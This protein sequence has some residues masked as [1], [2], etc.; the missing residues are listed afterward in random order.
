MPTRPLEDAWP[1]IVNSTGV[2]GTGT[3]ITKEKLDE[4]REAIDG[5]IY[6]PNLSEDPPA[7]A[8]EVTTARGGYVSVDAR[9]DA[10]EIAAAG[11]AASASSG[12]AQL[13]LCPNDP[14]VIWPDGDSAAPAFWE[15]DAGLT[16]TREGTQS[17]SSLGAYWGRS[18]VKLVA[19]A[20]KD[21]WIDL[22]TAA[23]L[24]S[25]NSPVLL[26]NRK[27]AVGVAIWTATQNLVEVHIDDGVTTIGASTKVGSNYGNTSA[28]VWSA[29]GHADKGGKALPSAPTRFR[30]LVRMTG[31]G[32]A[33]I[34]CP[35]G[36][37]AEQALFYVPAPSKIGTFVY[38][39]DAG[40]QILTGEKGRFYPARPIGLIDGRLLLETAGTGVTAEIY[41]D[42]SAVFGA[43]VA[44]TTSTDSGVKNPTSRAL[45]SFDVDNRISFNITVA[46]ST[47]RGPA[48][49]V[50]YIEF[51][52]FIESG[53]IGA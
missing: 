50:R 3:K 10:I 44:V 52:R 5:A 7:I 34:A 41:K 47:A 14:F 40:S 13:N 46:D 4:V 19:G 26:K 22:V 1:T 9:L 42:G 12:A 17:G 21:F 18:V 32:T 48:V 29:D 38:G 27:V 37:F 43:A 6:D 20:Q 36:Y 25:L 24:T 51:P 2:P 15:A 30:L 53:V 28:W 11:G 33:Y 45:A 8:R 16:V 39:Q 35:A 23:E 31:A 49:A